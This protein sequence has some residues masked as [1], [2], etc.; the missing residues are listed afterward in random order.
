MKLCLQILIWYALLLF[1]VGNG[2]AVW[3]AY[4]YLTK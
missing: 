2:L 3:G 4:Q 1:I